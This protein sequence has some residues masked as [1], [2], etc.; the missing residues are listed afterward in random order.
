[1]K[2]LAWREYVRLLLSYAVF[3]PSDDGSWTVEVPSLQGCVTWGQTRAEAAQMIEDAVEGWLA[4]ALRFGDPI[5][6]VDGCTLAYAAD[7]EP[8]E[9]LYAST[10]L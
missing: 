5:P 7:A 8:D 4:T 1:M 2:T 9:V 6:V 10:E 3:T